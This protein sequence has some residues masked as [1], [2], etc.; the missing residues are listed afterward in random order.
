[1]LLQA[2]PSTPRTAHQPRHLGPSTQ[3]AGRPPAVVVYTGFALY[4]LYC[5]LVS[6]VHSPFRP[7]V[8]E[9]PVRTVTLSHAQV[10]V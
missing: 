4:L 7:G 5:S 10:V 6:L 8:W 9:K 3:P 2:A 1:V